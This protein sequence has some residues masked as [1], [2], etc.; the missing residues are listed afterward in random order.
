MSG[1]KTHLFLSHKTKAHVVSVISLF[2]HSLKK[3][4]LQAA[5]RVLHYLKGSPGKG[6]Q[7]RGILFKR[8]PRLV[9]EVYIDADYVGSVVDRRSTTEYC[10]FLGGNLAI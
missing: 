2:M 10:T 1:R 3:V 6:L 4:H 9:L 7:E 8:S 5:N